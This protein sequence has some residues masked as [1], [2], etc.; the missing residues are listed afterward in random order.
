CPVPTF[1]GFTLTGYSCSSSSALQLK[2]ELLGRWE[3][4]RHMES[5]YHQGLLAPNPGGRGFRSSHREPIECRDVLVQN[6]LFTGDLEAVQKHFTESTAV[7]LIIES[8]GDELRWTSRKLGL[9]SLTYEQ[10]LTTPLHITAGRGYSEC[11]RHLLLR[12]A[13]VDFAPGGKTALHEACAAARTECVR[14]LLSF[15]A[16]PEAVSEAGY[17]PLHL[18][19]SPDSLQCAKLLLQH[20]ASVNSR[21]EEE[22]DTALHVVARHGLE[23]HVQLFL[24]HGAWLEARNEEEQ[25]PL[26]TACAQSHPPKELDRCSPS[27][28][29]SPAPPAAASARHQ[30]AKS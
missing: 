14:L 28:A 2:E 12:G 30:Q 22:E 13:A 10:E 1:P 9:W 19:K 6:A 20:G 21:T 3:C 17:R 27:R 29:L 4:T 11:L 23:E 18:C 15:G 7:N 5:C 26:N 25:T 8:K 24:R 16:E